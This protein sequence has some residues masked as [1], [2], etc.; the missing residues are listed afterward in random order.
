MIDTSAELKGVIDLIASGFFSPEEPALHQP[1]VQALTKEDPY[2]LCADFDAYVACQDAVD[3]VYR[4]EERWT[5]MAIANI[6]KS[7]KFS[8]DRTI[9]EYA[10][11]IW[12]AS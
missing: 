1:V 6:A 10:R 4:D 2:L 3:A 9:R 7:G 5:R 8:S 12:R 11:D